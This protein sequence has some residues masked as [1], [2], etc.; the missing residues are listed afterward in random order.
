MCAEIPNMP[1]VRTSISLDQELLEWVNQ[2]LENNYIYKDR[3]HYIEVLIR[4][5]RENLDKS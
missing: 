2:H 5:D 3:S 1:K 4:K